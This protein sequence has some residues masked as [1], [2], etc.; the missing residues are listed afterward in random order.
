MG[1]TGGSSTIEQR[2]GNADLGGTEPAAWS[3]QTAER[4]DTFESSD[5]VARLE[6]LL[7]ARASELSM[8]R[9]EL[10]RT[11]E[12]LRD[13]A[14][15]FERS[16]ARAA[17]ADP[18]E[19]RRARDAAVVRAIEAEAGRADLAFRLDELLGHIAQPTAAGSLPAP[20]LGE[21]LDVLCARLNGT[22]R[23]LTSALAET[24]EVRDSAGARLMLAEQD[25]AMLASRSRLIERELAEAREQV[26]LEALHS[27]ALTQRIEGSLPVREAAQLGGELAGLRARCDEAERV[28][29]ELS[30]ELIIAR[31]TARPGAAAAPESSSGVER[32]TELERMLA[33]EIEKGRE[34]AAELARVVA[35]RMVLGE[36]L[37][38]AQADAAGLRNALAALTHEL[39]AE[40][41]AAR[42]GVTEQRTQAERLRDALREA[43]QV[44]GELSGAL[45]RASRPPPP[46]TRD[47]YDDTS[48]E[49]TQPGMPTYIEAM[50]GLEELVALRDEH[51]RSLTTTLQLE[52]DRL[53]AVERIVAVLEPSA[54]LL[55]AAAWAELVELLH[56]R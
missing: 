12:L 39:D 27:R 6:A 31:D 17:D 48:G 49:P 50:E 54:H 16:A 15:S 47:S 55:P 29:A 21:P 38:R 26:E 34:A 33:R 2:N 18:S 11:R 51:I 9:H 14:A 45:E 46:D 53:R 56:R 8:A 4:V 24:E 10:A 1:G 36:E 40:R 13:A 7:A 5:E 32:N 41:G 42:R 25:L 23:G 22:V 28:I 30:K 52:R 44:L 35:E 3:E 43:R 20:D 37:A 19:L